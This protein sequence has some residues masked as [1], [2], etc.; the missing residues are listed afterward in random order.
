MP[1]I[2]HWELSNWDDCPFRHKLLHLDKVGKFERN[3]FS[4]FGIAVHNCCER[5]FMD[6]EQMR[7]NPGRGIGWV[8]STTVADY[9]I[10]EFAKALKETKEHKELDK[11]L[12]IAMAEQGKK[13]LPMVID[14][15]TKQFPNAKFVSAEERF[16]ESIDDNEFEYDFKGKMDLVLQTEDGVYHIIDWK[17]STW[18]WNAR[19]RGDK[20]VN[21]QLTYY[22]HF[23]AKKHG[24]DPDK[25]ETHF[26]LL[27]RTVKEDN[28]EFIDV[29][30]GPKRVSNALGFVNNAI[31]NIKKGNFIKNRLSCKFC[32]FKDTA[33]CP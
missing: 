5:L 4:A 19:K 28:V 8:T 16:K 27:K 11:E 6:R 1:H 25:I 31:K 23:F 10:K 14:A 33:F 32:E 30:N 15:T 29:T 26:A 18:G 3:E 13:I 24:I 9:F 12:V 22:K 20:M 17:T 2:S 7:K 21:Y